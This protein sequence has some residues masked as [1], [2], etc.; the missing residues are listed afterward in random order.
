MQGDDPTGRFGKPIRLTD[1]TPA[2]LR[3][4]VGTD[5][6]VLQD[7]YTALSQVS[8]RSRFQ[9]APPRLTNGMLD[10]LVGD[11]DQFDHVAFLLLAPAGHTAETPVGVGRIIRYAQ[12]SSIAD[13]ALAVAD[14]WQDRGV[15]SALADALVQCRPDGVTHLRTVVSADNTASLAILAKLGRVE[16]TSTE[17]GQVDVSISLI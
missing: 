14:D 12:D 6:Q 2:R 13:I 3:A 16:R 11:V 9:S 7:I 8:R 5:R 15:G 17:A 4:L 10:H 1:G